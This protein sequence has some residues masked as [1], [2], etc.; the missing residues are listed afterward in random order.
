MTSVQFVSASWDSNL[1][2]CLKQ[3]ALQVLEN[4]SQILSC[5]LV[6]RYYNVTLMF[7]NFQY[8][9]LNNSETPH[10]LLLT[11]QQCRFHTLFCLLLVPPPRSPS[12]GSFK[13]LG[14]LGEGR[15]VLGLLGWVFFFFPEVCSWSCAF[16][17][18]FHKGIVYRRNWLNC[19]IYEGFTWAAFW[20]LCVRSFGWG[21]WIW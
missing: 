1:H 8:Q 6:R 7:E 16:S 15:G 3:T 11:L 10:Q 14:I 19:K 9:M 2:F 20:G 4:P 13:Y 21:Y 12:Q 5:T 17:P 18:S